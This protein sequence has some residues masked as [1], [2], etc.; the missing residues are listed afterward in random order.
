[1]TPH[2]K[3][4]TSSPEGLELLVRFYSEIYE[5]GLP[6]PNERES[7]ENMKRYLKLKKEGWY[8]DNSYHIILVLEGDK[9][10]AGSV[11][12]YLAFPNCGVIEFI[13]VND[14]I[15]GRG[16]GKKLHDATLEAFNGDAR[17]NGYPH[18]EGVAIELNDPYQ[19]APSDDYCDPFERAMIWDR[20]GYRR[21]RFPYT[22]PALSEDQS[23]V[24]C[25]LLAMK[26]D[27]SKY[28]AGLP[29]PLV[30]D[31]L[32]G[33]SKWAMRI[34]D[35]KSH[36]VFKSMQDYLSALPVVSAESLSVYI[37]R[38][39]DKPLYVSAVETP[40]S[41]V[42]E[43]VTG[44]YARA[45]P[46]G[47]TAIGVDMFK[48]ALVSYS[49]RKD[50]RYHLWALSDKSG[51]PASGMVSFFTMQRFG[52]GGYLALEPPLKGSRRTGIILRRIEE[53]M[54]RHSAD[55]Q[56]YYIECLPGSSEEAIFRR[57]GFWPTPITYYQPVLTKETLF[58]PETGPRVTLMM[59]RLGHGYAGEDFSPDDFLEDLT[60]LLTEVYSLR[61]PQSSGTFQIAKETLKR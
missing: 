49:D 13:L 7:L 52:F 16:I 21:L 39:P 2:T 17:N 23:Q 15:R 58:V 51:S 24:S 26:F 14:D 50:V 33:Y 45:F 35:P 31:V 34:Q 29:S 53:C 11:S 59:K 9:I 47:P 48:M 57:L 61:N 27:A 44:I 18:I 5:K 38:D 41:P 55:A 3:E 12:D 4:L 28:R 40:D 8:G 43:A 60:V 42:Y 19:V 32:E 1:M 25:L 37:G 46:P 30:L 10:I 22:Q 20:W 6:D 54:I 56:H 36:P